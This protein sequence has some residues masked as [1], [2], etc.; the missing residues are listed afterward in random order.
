MR[1]IFLYLYHHCSYEF[2]FLNFHSSKC[3]KS[4][5]LLAEL[6]IF[7][8]SSG[9]QN[10]KEYKLKTNF[11]NNLQKSLFTISEKLFSKNVEADPN[12]A[13]SESI[14]LEKLDNYANERW[15]VST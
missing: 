9:V 11:K 3:Q 4:I 6:G 15:E 1:K 12:Q 8:E 10:Q 14:D 5:Q 13:K 7:E 2:F